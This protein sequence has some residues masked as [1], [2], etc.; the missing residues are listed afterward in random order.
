MA[1]S[2]RAPLLS[3]DDSGDH[4]DTHDTHENEN[5]N[6]NDDFESTPLVRSSSGTPR[7]DGDD[8]QPG[9]GASI[10][11]RGT[12]AGSIKSSKRRKTRWPSIIAMIILAFIGLAVLVLAF[13]VPPALQEYAKEAVVLEPTNLSLE[14]ITAHGIRARVQLNFRVEA[15]R[16]ENEHVRRIG[17]TVS[18]IV[19]EMGTGKTKI[20][21]HLPDYKN[22]LL[23]SAVVP[24]TSASIVD[25]ENTAVDFVA[26]LAAG[27]AEGIRRIANQWLE[28]KLKNVQI[29]GE[30]DV[31][32]NAG[33]IPLGTHFIENSLTF[34]GQD[35]YRSFA[36]LYLGE[37]SLV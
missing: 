21:F 7:Y 8:D 35:L 22:A 28:G 32:F 13:I 1:D 25:G 20:N 30:A 36:S 2:E 15:Q 33:I 5:D 27:E 34:E 11:S 14:S 17:K 18:W 23:G 26:E 3:A 24:P 16:V 29:R 6:D 19:R 37:K 31:Q 10:A 12:G 9:D 4:H